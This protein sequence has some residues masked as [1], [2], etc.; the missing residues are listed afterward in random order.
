MLTAQTAG[1]HVGVGT[2]N[3]VGNGAGP[4]VG[5]KNGTDIGTSPL[6]SYRNYKILILINNN[7]ILPNRRCR[8]GVRYVSNF[9]MRQMLGPRQSRERRIEGEVR[10]KK[11]KKRNNVTNGIRSQKP[12]AILT[13]KLTRDLGRDR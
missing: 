9:G 10:S 12:L 11:K 6:S 5:T 2:E 7:E 4:C 8:T 1:T 13:K 3:V